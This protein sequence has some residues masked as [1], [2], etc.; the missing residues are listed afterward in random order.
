MRARIGRLA[1]PGEVLVSAAAVDLLQ[2]SRF[3]FEERGAHELKGLSG[4]RAIYA[5]VGQVSQPA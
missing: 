4:S 5:Y 1:E 3:R 2:A